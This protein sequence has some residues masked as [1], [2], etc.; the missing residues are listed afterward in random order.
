MNIHDFDDARLMQLLA[1]T[2][3]VVEA[4][5]DD[6]VS[7]AYAAADLRLIS[8]ELATLVFD[9]GSERELAGM[10]SAGVEARLL[11]FVHE[12][13][14]VDLQLPGD[15]HA[16]VGQITPAGDHVVVVETEDGQTIDVD[17]DEYGRFRTAVP[18][19]RLRVR[20]AGLLVTPW[21]GR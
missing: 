1:D 13:V 5:P 12:D 20:I 18:E 21:V 4:V 10:R 16:L 2:L 7:A 6:A 19:G 15:S 14:T 9:S 11:S 3:A 17:A 8:E